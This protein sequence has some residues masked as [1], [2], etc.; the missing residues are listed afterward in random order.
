MSIIPFILDGLVLLFLGITV[1]FAS[2]LSVQLKVFRQTR[3]DLK[4]LIGDLSGQ[5][6]QAEMA[7]TGLREAA[8]ESGRDLQE[9]ISQASALKDEMEMIYDSSNRLVD[10]LEQSPGRKS[11]MP[12]EADYMESE[13]RQNAHKQ[14][15]A[16]K[17]PEKPSGTSPFSIRDPEYLDGE[18]DDLD[19]AGGYDEELEAFQSR[20][21]KELF[22]AL[23]GKKKVKVAGDI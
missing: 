3:T 20:A 15:N 18:D 22:E 19:T 14:Q 8:R 7:I 17:S 23:S 4:G 12:S 5:I 13:D 21:E 2:R 11:A 9:M 1:F 10:R 6:T 16:P